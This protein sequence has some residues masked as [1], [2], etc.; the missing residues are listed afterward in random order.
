MQGDTG[1]AEEEKHNDRRD[2]ISLKGQLEHSMSAPAGSPA[3]SSAET[4][5]SVDSGTP[6]SDS[7]RPG[8]TPH[9]K[10]NISRMPNIVD[11]YSGLLDDLTS[12]QRWGLIARLSNGYYEGWRPTR[13]QLSRYLYHEFGVTTFSHHSLPSE[14]RRRSETNHDKN[15][16]N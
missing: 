15:T 6:K 12:R 8:S 7:P 16:D 10:H 14:T 13:A 5:T 1:Q 2:D 11:Q 9:A 3:A 4:G